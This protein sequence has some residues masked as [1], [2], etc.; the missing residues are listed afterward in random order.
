MNTGRN[1]GWRRI[2]RWLRRNMPRSVPNSP[3]K[4]AWDAAPAAIRRGAVQR[5]RP[6]GRRP[7]KGA[8][9]ALFIE[10][11]ALPRSVIPGLVPGIQVDGR[12]KPGHEEARTK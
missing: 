4:L 7:K 2:T 3:K 10:D 5:N 6:P 1:G 8:D 11:R 12:V 9:G